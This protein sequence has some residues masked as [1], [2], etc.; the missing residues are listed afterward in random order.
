MVHLWVTGVRVPLLLPLAAATAAAAAAVPPPLL[1]PP[2][3]PLLLLPLPPPLLLH[4]GGSSSVRSHTGRPLRRSL[5]IL[6]V[7]CDPKCME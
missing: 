1:P 7:V 6:V 2:L 5:V 4:A 3:L